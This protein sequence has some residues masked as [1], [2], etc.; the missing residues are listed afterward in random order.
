MKK[1]SSNLDSYN[2]GVYD[3]GVILGRFLPFHKGHE[4]LVRTGKHN[5]KNLFVFVCERD[6]DP[7]DG[8]TRAAWIRDTV[9]GVDVRVMDCNHLPHEGAKLWADATIEQLGRKP[10]VAFSSEAYGSP[11]CKEMGADHFMV[12][13]SRSTIDISGTRVR[14][15]PLER[16]M[17]L[18]PATRVSY[19]KR[20][21][22]LGSA[23]KL[24]KEM[25]E[26]ISQEYKSPLVPEWGRS[27]VNA[28]PFS[29]AYRWQESDFIQIAR[30]QNYLEDETARY[31]GPMMICETNSWLV[32]R[33]HERYRN[34]ENSLTVDAYSRGRKYDG[35]FLIGK[36]ND[37]ER[38][39]LIRE[40]IPILYEG[41]DPSETLQAAKTWIDKE[42]P[43]EAWTNW[44]REELIDVSQLPYRDYK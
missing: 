11:W 23:E 32:G 1:P 37:L 27:Y 25:A 33:F 14:E 19:T 5:S 43:A 42:I 30:Q 20:I 28:I 41:E 6:S 15:A 3:T 22:F 34:G 7:M 4:Y 31:A 12:D 8:L 2:K 16:M 44:K 29:H 38:E 24:R 26:M 10:D 39:Y 18:P 36:E 17:M 13:H 21:L 40:N 35:A 9:P